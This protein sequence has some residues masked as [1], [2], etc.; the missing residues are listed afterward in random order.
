MDRT[1]IAEAESRAGWA[2]VFAG[3]VG[4]LMSFGSVA[5]YS[6]TVFVKPLT[7]TFGWSRGAVSFAFTAAC[8]A[9]LVS[10]LLVG[11]F[12]DRAGGRAV[13]LAATTLFGVAFC[14]LG[15]VSGRIWQF[16]A[17]FVCLGLVGAGT[18]A[19]PYSSVVSHWFDARR[20][21]ALG[22]TMSGL[23]LGSAAAPTVAQVLID[24]VGWRGAYIALGG[25]VL[26][27][28]CPI[29]FLWFREPGRRLVAATTLP[30]RSS[31]N[32]LG[33]VAGRVALRGATLWT[34][35]A[36][37][38]LV[39]AASQGCLIHLVPLLTDRG[40]SAEWAALAASLFGVTNLVGRLAGGYLLDRVFA[41]YV[42]VASLAG[43]AVGIVLL[44]GDARLAV[45]AVIL[46]GLSAGVET[47]AIPYLVGRYF[48]LRS[49]G[50]IY[51]YLFMTV[52]LGGAV[53]PLLVGVAFDKTGTYTVPLAACA[54]GMLVAAVLFTR[55]GAYP[56]WTSAAEIGARGDELASA[57]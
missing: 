38:L 37:L 9:A 45:P 39:S 12:V 23:G 46:M 47:D 53:G 11:R 27:V 26:L 30:D 18:A 13:A 8:L 55:L 34:L 21:L 51:S 43:A 52:P 57:L 31:P 15:F 5:V 40:L 17:V 32:V 36:A 14:A 3:A 4:L 48:G 28:A 7:E 33:G 20:G 35:L 10:L 6:F 22:L 2:A 25:A 1:V 41:P 16:Y 54:A 29:L 49:F 44:L 19:I 24:R 50:E 56:S 42:V